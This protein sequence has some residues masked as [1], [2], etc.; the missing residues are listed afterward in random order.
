MPM[1]TSESHLEQGMN[2]NLIRS[3]VWNQHSLMPCFFVRFREEDSMTRRDDVT[4]TR[5]RRDRFVDSQRGG[6]VG[7]RAGVFG[8]RAWVGGD[9]DAAFILG[10][11]FPRRHS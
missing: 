7:G 10:E 2:I 9:C 1:S 11:D 3:D 5:D 6:V 4:S 8:E